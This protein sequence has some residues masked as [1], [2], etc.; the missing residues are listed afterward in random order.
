MRPWGGALSSRG[1]DTLALRNRD[2]KGLLTGQIQRLKL[3]HARVFSTNPYITIR[4]MSQ[5]KEP[6]QVVGTQVGT[7]VVNLF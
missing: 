2:Y 3:L 7:Q 6:L 4:H 1:G 5:Q